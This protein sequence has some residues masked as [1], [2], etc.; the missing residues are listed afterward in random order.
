MTPIWPITTL[1]GNFERTFAMFISDGPRKDEPR[2]ATVK[3][4]ERII[5]TTVLFEEPTMLTAIIPAMKDNPDSNDARTTK[6]S[7][8]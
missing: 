1:D 2:P 7:M 6:K 4:M 3:L 8:V 5:K